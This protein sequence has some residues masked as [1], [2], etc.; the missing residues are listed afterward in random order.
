MK[1]RVI[2]FLGCT[3]S[4]VSLT[5]LAAEKHSNHSSDSEHHSVAS[6]SAHLN[7]EKPNLSY[8]SEGGQATFSALVEIVALLE[9]DENTDWENVNIDLLRTHLLDMDNL[10]RKT[11]ASSTVAGDR[12]IIFN[13]IGDNE[14][15]SAIHNM[16]PAHARFIQDSRG[17]E[18]QTNLNPTGAV[19]SISVNTDSDF[20]MMQALGF[21]GFMSMDSHH[22]MHHYQMALGKSH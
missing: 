20:K 17:W 13:V 15:I 9:Q 21:Y 5:L 1:N 2:I 22:P 10:V 11:T 7:G 3:I 19:L 6:E 12:K 4:F 18:I 14:A 8:P 16:A